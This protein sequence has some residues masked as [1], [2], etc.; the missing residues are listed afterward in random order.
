MRGFELKIFLCLGA[1]VSKSDYH[2]ISLYNVIPESDISYHRRKKLLIVQQSLLV[3][4]L[5]RCMENSIKNMHT[6]EC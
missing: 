3:S 5:R 2:L 1:S 6:N 4:P